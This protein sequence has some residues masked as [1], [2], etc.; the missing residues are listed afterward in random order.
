[1]IMNNHAQ[2]LTL[3]VGVEQSGSD[4]QKQGLYC[5]IFE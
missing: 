4:G 5:N 2:T 1:M 3:V